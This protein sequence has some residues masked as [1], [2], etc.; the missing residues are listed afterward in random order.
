[1]AEIWSGNPKK[2]KDTK[3]EAENPKFLRLDHFLFFLNFPYILKNPKKIYLDL[4]DF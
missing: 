2:I 4:F 1:L 3:I